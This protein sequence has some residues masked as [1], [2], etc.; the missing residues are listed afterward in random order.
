MSF[1][2]R[3]GHVLLARV[4]H[5][6]VCNECITLGHIFIELALR[7][8]N[9][10]RNYGHKCVKGAVLAIAMDSESK[11]QAAFKEFEKSRETMVDPCLSLT[12]CFP[13]AVHVGKRIS[14]SFSNWF[15]IVQGYRINRVLLRTLRNDPYVKEHLKPHLSLASCRNKDR[16]DVES[17]LEI[18]SPA[19]QTVIK[20][21]I[22]TSV[23]ETIVPE[24]YRVYDG[25]K[26]GVLQN[27]TGVCVGPHGTIFVADTTKG[28]VFSARLHY[29]VDVSE[30]CTS[31]EQPAS[32]AY[33]DG[34]LYVAE[35]ITGS[36]VCI[37]IEGNTVLNPMKMTVAQIQK[38]LKDR[39]MF[40]PDDRK[41]KKAALQ[42]KLEDWLKTVKSRPRNIDG[43]QESQDNAQQSSAKSTTNTVCTLKS[44]TKFT[45]PVALCH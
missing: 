29:P 33:G 5:G 17:F 43:V 11:N 4:E 2:A 6:K 12:S 34:V 39:N 9:R 16:M 35:K 36:V 8:C 14:R 31:L 22:K 20:E 27:P 37:D 40:H 41:L 18:C 1:D 23:V 19:V 30:V 24:K 13:D 26:T 10:C 42:K 7:S 25:N 3:S 32:V 38:C 44:S 21:H 28:K 15:I 45:N